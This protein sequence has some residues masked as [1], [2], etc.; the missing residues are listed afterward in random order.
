MPVDPVMRDNLDEFVRKATGDNT[1]E[2]AEDPPQQGP[3]EVK[4]L[5]PLKHKADS[6]YCCFC[7]LQSDDIDLEYGEP[8]RRDGHYESECRFRDRGAH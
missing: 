7:G 6:T 3:E 5:L 2:Y 1:F 8:K 4:K